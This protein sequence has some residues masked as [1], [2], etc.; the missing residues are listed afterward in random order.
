MYTLSVA[1]N[2]SI[3]SMYQPFESVDAIVMREVIGMFSGKSFSV[4]NLC[5]VLGS[6]MP[7]LFFM[8]VVRKC[9]DNSS[10]I[11][12]PVLT[13]IFSVLSRVMYRTV[14]YNSS[15]TDSLDFHTILILKKNKEA[16]QLLRPPLM[17]EEREVGLS[18]S[19]IP[20]VH[21]SKLR[22][23]RKDSEASLDKYLLSKNSVGTKYKIFR[24]Q[25]SMS[26]FITG[27]ANTMYPSSNYKRLASSVS[28]FFRVCKLTERI[29]VAG[30]LLNGVPGLGKT[31]FI[32][33]AV[34]TK[35]VNEV[36][37]IDMTCLLNETFDTILKNAYHSVPCKNEK[38]MFVFDELDKYLDYRC[39]V[40]YDNYLQLSETKE[41]LVVK[42]EKAFI[43][44][45]KTDFLFSMLRILERSDLSESIVVIFCTNNFESIFEGVNLKHHASLVSRFKQFNFEKCDQKEL[46]NYLLHYNTAFLGTEFYEEVD[47]KWIMENLRENISIT[48]RALH[49]LSFEASYGVKETIRLLNCYE[50][51]VEH[52]DMA[53]E[54]EDRAPVYTTKNIKKEVAVVE[55]SSDEDSSEDSESEEISRVYT[56]KN[57]KY[58]EESE[59]EEISQR[60]FDSIRVV[61]PKMITEKD[62]NQSFVDI[63]LSEQKKKENALMFEVEYGVKCI[64]AYKTEFSR[65]PNIKQV[66]TNTI[67]D[68]LLA[69]SSLPSGDAKVSNII[70]LYDY[71]ASDDVTIGF[72][73]SCDKLKES[74]R[75]KVMKFH[76]ERPGMFGSC[77]PQTKKFLSLFV[78][79]LDIA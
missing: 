48:N 65:D 46:C 58:R 69:N 67:G 66:I 18:V 4:G 39:H 19:Y 38:I 31:R 23:I 35:L 27:E 63:E 25:N 40:L 70:Q 57:V 26:S 42:S 79:E 56:K 10:L 41:A 60:S 51:E 16:L 77:N 15:D 43:V 78:R 61:E 68:H 74:V 59:D 45:K 52:Y 71:L 20:F 76:S 54:I 7:K 3:I 53:E 21:S 5:T 30:I 44:D 22:D 62:S 55:S 72:V 37:K 75:G 29:E 49:H 11:T 24:I 1:P 17:I 32:D 47:E 6:K 14:I 36:Y 33:Y 13:L 50:E 12:S 8:I 9:L 64:E 28:S 73:L 34:K 2:E